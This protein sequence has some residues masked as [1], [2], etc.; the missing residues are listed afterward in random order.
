MPRWMEET[1]LA[2]INNTNAW[3]LG[4]TLNFLFFPRG[5]SHPG[6][7]LPLRQPL[8]GDLG[9]SHPISWMEKLRFRDGFDIPAGN[10]QE[11]DAHLRG[12]RELK[13]ELFAKAE[14]GLREL[15]GVAE[16]P[17]ADKCG[18]TIAGFR[19]NEAGDVEVSGTW[20]EQQFR[21]A[22]PGRSCRFG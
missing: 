14:V 22:L 10:S 2:F 5:F 6:S 21:R 17:E 11:I 7:A 15:R 4:G 13:E 12:Q 9:R 19:P 16:N 8:Q 18:E 1:Y 3:L 20:R